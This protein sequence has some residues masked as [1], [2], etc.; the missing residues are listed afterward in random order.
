MKAY[1]ISGMAADSRIFKHIKLPKGIEEVHLN[2][3]IPDGGE[4]LR[5]YAVRLGKQ[6][7]RSDPFILIGYSLGGIIAVEIANHYK[8]AGTVLIA[9]ISKSSQLPGY[10]RTFQR[11]NLHKMIPGSAL[12]TAA[13][14]K[15]FLSSEA[16]EDKKLIQI[17]IRET[18]SRFVKWGIK[19]VLEWENEVV[20][21][22]LMHIHGPKD[23]VFPIISTKP[24][25]II[26][27]A[28]HSILMSH[29]KEVNNILGQLLST[30]SAPFQHP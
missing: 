1:L 21:R 29:S 15:H 10:Y 16:L 27:Q 19:A 6:I 5:A 4:S 22:P 18:D 17:M 23:E 11:F 20:P 8:P 25:H 30:F 12:K 24:T 14:T 26:H 28:G 7:D 3:I 13:I 2:W 9:S